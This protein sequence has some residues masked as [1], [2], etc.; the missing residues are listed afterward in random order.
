MSE[1]GWWLTLRPPTRP[2]QL[3]DSLRGL[4]LFPQEETWWFAW[5]ETEIRLPGVLREP[6][7][8]DDG[9]E[10]LRVFS[11]QAEL[12]LGR[13]GRGRG[14]WLL[15]EEGA[16]EVINRLPDGAVLQQMACWV[17]PAHRILWG[18]KMVLP[19]RRTVRGE[20]IFPRELTYDLDGDRPERALVAEVQL[21]YDREGRLQTSRYVRL[22]LVEHEGF[23]RLP[24]RPYPAPD[25]AVGLADRQAEE[26][27]W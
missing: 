4:G 9:W 27:G 10:V 25:V 23:K 8:L 6:M 15:L 11:P 24:P 14:C 5:R 20:V 7:D 13:R 21:Y 1:Q 2:S 16:E 19:G 26:E 18:R 12:R 17:E 22:R 3:L